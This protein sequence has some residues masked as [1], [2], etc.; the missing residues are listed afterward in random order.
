MH[1]YVPLRSLIHKAADDGREDTAGYLSN[2]EISKIILEANSV[3][4]YWDTTSNS[5][6][7]IYDSK[8]LVDLESYAF[9]Q[10]NTSADH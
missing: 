6:I 9:K 2:A 8:R 3:E 5:D 1:W 7:V 10:R 4:G